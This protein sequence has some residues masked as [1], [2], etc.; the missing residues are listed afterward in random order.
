MKQYLGN[1]NKPTSEKS[2]EVNIEKTELFENFTGF[3]II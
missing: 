2:V 3:G 1:S